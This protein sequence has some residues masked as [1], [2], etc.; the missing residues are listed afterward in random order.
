MRPAFLDRAI[1]LLEGRKIDEWLDR[2]A[3][4]AR[5]QRHVHLAIDLYIVKIGA[6]NQGQNL[7]RFWPN[8]DQRPIRDIVL[9]QGGHLVVYN[10]F[11]FRLQL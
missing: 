10:T 4:L 7:A 2:A 5:G 8:G 9:G 11:S 6:A 3:G 1:R